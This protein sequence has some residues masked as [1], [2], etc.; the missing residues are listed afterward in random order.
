M[1]NNIMYDYA[2]FV[3]EVNRY[4]SQQR[5]NSNM[6]VVKALDDTI[7][8]YDLLNKLNPEEANMYLQILFASLTA[9]TIRK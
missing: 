5:L 7:K 8:V 4:V 3:R 9:S 1:N 6:K 2:T